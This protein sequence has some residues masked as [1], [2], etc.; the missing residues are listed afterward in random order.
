[1]ISGLPTTRFQPPQTWRSSGSIGIYRPRS[2]DHSQ[3]SIGG[4]TTAKSSEVSRNVVSI[5][6]L[7]DMLPVKRQLASKY[8][9]LPWM[10][11]ATSWPRFGVSLS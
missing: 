6:D 7:S 3:R 2:T 4:A 11:G 8:R 10:Q 1:M 9:I 5:H